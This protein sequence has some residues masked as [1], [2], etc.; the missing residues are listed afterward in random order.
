MTPQHIDVDVILN[1]YETYLDPL[2]KVRQEQMNSSF[3]RPD[4]PEPQLDDIEAEI[5]YLLLRT[6]K[7]QTV[8]EIGSFNGWSTTWILHALRDNGSGQLITHDIIDNARSQVP[9]ELSNGRWTFV[10]GDVRQ[11]LEVAPS[12]IDYLFI[13]AAHSWP[14]AKWY[15][16]E[17][18]PLLAPGTPTSVHDVYHHR[19]PVPFSEGHALVNWLNGRKLDRFTASRAH[20]RETY[21]RILAFK[22]SHGLDEP[23]HSKSANPMVFFL[24]P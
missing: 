5:T 17:L 24:S 8:L 12:S 13:D 2:R 4:G 19:F 21:E 23:V 9:D 14:F 10:Q 15:L 20:A 1:A 22:R 11:T 16:R 18:L 7:P 3:I 6:F